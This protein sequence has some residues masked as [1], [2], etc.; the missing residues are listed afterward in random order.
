M[1]RLW[2]FVVPAPPP[3]PPGPPPPNGFAPPRPPPPPPPP[4]PR[5]PPPPPAFAP[6]PLVSG[7][8]P[9][10]FAKRRFRVKR[11]GPVRKLMGTSFEPGCGMVSN[12]PNPG[13]VTI[14][15]GKA[16]GQVLEAV[17]NDGR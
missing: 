11:L 3:P 1:V 17:A 15:C 5:P 7:P 16:A 9:K 10:V 12:V 8:K 13:T 2:R 4:P 6:C 14:H